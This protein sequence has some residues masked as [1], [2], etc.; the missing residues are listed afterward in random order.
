MKNSIVRNS[1]ILFALML[2]SKVVGILREVVLAHFYGASSVSDAYIIAISSYTMLFSA[3]SSAVTVSYIQHISTNEKKRDEITSKL[4]ASVSIIVFL[5]SALICIFPN[6]FLN[7]FA[8]GLD[9]ETKT[10]TTQMLYFIL[11]VCF[12]LS[13]RYI[14]N[15]FLQ[16]K[17]IFWMSGINNVITSVLVV[18]AIIV[19]SS[20][21][22]ILPL[23]ETV[24]IIVSFIVTLIIV[25]KHGF[26]FVKNKLLDITE[27][28]PIIILMI[29]LF[30][31]QLVQQFN[32]IVDKN[33]AS[34][35]GEGIISSINYANKVNILFSTFFVA[36]ITT[37]LFPSLSKL[38]T[39]N[40]EKF[41]ELGTK[42]TKVVLMTA[43]PV[44]VAIFLLAEELIAVLYMR[45][46]FNIADL[47]ITSEILMIYSLSIPA[48][49]MNDLLNKQF[50]AMG[51][52]KTPVILSVISLCVNI[53]LNFIWVKSLGYIGLATSTTISVT[54][55]AIMLNFTFTKKYKINL[56]K[57]KVKDYIGV[58]VSSV[59]M[60][61]TVVLVLTLFSSLSYLLV[62]IISAVIGVLI[63][64]VG[65]ML[66]KDEDISTIKKS[67]MGRLKR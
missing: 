42:A 66:F 1:T 5:V 62:L 7:L 39:E 38:K 55:L 60:G 46:E 64:V 36:S 22:L 29:P 54:L 49:S 48:L 19:S 2:V 32:V 21:Y 6:L 56:F 34:M 47:K 12:L 17:G 24:G 23:G 37:V 67:V 26:K 35:V 4:I 51:N 40:I 41:K 16:T 53:V 14:F 28:K 43:I 65:L 31:G 10:L 58:L 45:G 63:Y 11:P 8:V 3:L 30:L 33:F 9:E 52:T 18:V 57:N 61:G 59:V 44:A 15:G 20:N 50:Y 25:R 13:V 27:V